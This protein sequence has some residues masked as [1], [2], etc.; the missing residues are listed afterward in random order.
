[1]SA[2]WL[3][4]CLRENYTL[5]KSKCFIMLRNVS[6]VHS[7][8]YPVGAR[9]W[10]SK[11]AEA[12]SRLLIGQVQHQT[13]YP[14]VWARAVG[15]YEVGLGSCFPGG[16]ATGAWNWP[17]SPIAEDKNA[18]RELY[19]FFPVLVCWCLIGHKDN[20]FTFTFIGICMLLRQ[21]NNS[22]LK[23]QYVGLQANLLALRAVRT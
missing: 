2:K 10:G 20:F 3:A 21:W 11:E 13:C 1:L 16:K 6:G 14:Y 17:L 18:S 9:F 8:S 22:N 19:I 23:W 7:V 5:S 4:V 12:W 15:S